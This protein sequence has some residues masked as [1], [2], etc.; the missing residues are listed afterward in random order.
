MR[1]FGRNSP[2]IGRGIDHQ[3]VDHVNA[4][5]RASGERRIVTTLSRLAEAASGLAGPALLIVG[6]AMSLAQAGEGRAELNAILKE[7]RA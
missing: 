4:P 3:A 7:A 6:E 2:L 5:L 1:L